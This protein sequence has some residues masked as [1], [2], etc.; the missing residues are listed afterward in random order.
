MNKQDLIVDLKLMQQEME[1]AV[2]PRVSVY[3]SAKRLDELGWLN[4]HPPKRDYVFMQ[5]N[6]YETSS[7]FLPLG[8]TAMLISPGGL[9]KTFALIQCAIAAATGTK[10][11]GTF[12]ASQPSTV[13]LITAEEDEIEIWRRI[14]NIFFGLGLNK[15]RKAAALLGMNLIPLPLYGSRQRFIDKDGKETSEFNDL[16]RLLHRVDDC[17]LVILDPASYFMGPECEVDNAAATDWITLLNQLTKTPGN[18]AVLIAHHTNKGSIKPSSGE[19]SSAINQSAARGSSALVD[20]VRWVAA[21][22]KKAEENHDKIIFKLVKSNHCSTPEPLELYRDFTH[23]G[24][25][26]PSP[27]PEN[28]ESPKE[29]AAI[30]RPKWPAYTPEEPEEYDDSVKTQAELDYV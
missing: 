9:G 8:K 29:V 15:D 30:A 5:P 16:K 27:S 10:W 17:R 19:N 28:K 14:R 4:D 13:V 22:Q 23:D 21:L 26:Q 20:G 2:T 12:Q 24:I 11:F 1:Q 25:L 6:A 18:P 7:G 3:D